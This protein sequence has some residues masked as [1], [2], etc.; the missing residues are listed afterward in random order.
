MRISVT[1][2]SVLKLALKLPRAALSAAHLADT[3]ASRGG[4]AIIG[5]SLAALLIFLHV[6]AGDAAVRRNMALIAQLVTVKLID[7]RWDVAALRS[8]SAATSSTPVAQDADTA[9]IQ[10]TLDA[11][12]THAKTAAMRSAI[13]D[14]RK[15]YIE[16]AD[17]VARLEKASTDS[18]RALAA[19]MRADAAV[20]A[21]VR[22]AWPDF[23]QRERLVAA[24]TLVAR[25]L[26]EVQQ[27][28]HT[29]SAAHRAT[30]EAYAADLPRAQALPRPVQAG[31]ARLESDVHQILQL[32]PLEQVL[33]ERLTSLN[34]GSRIDDIIVVFQ[35]ELADAL[36]RRDRY[37]LALIVYTVLLIVLLAYFARRA[38]ARYRDV[39][40]LYSRQTADLARALR[41]LHD[42]E[43]PAQL[44]EAQR[45]V[46]GEADE[47]AQII[48]EYR[49]Q[50]DAAPRNHGL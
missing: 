13:A 43:P 36:A 16:K 42:L 17:V 34:T 24:E 4:I 18:G 1:E 8:R 40:I 19:A 11:A 23:P 49:R 35:R 12:G 25:V 26:A 7:T 14:I 28:H 32:K 21:L 38:Y 47:T 31:L 15:A 6:M 48:S 41:K 27:Y 2:W 44:T 39:G 29:P 22:S 45:R 33:S 20:S 3:L 10:R 5:L 37:R 30:L 50:P 9:L 46:E